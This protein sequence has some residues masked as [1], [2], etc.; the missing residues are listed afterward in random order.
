MSR[1]PHVPALDVPSLSVHAE[2]VHEAS[3]PR[4]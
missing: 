1:T 2:V 3:N 4:Q